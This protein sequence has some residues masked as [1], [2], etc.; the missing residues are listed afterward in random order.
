MLMGNLESASTGQL[1]AEIASCAPDQVALVHIGLGQH[2]EAM[3]WLEK[4]Y[5]EDAYGMVFL[6]GDPAVRSS[7]LGSALP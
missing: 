3:D 5:T 1:W 2:D 6:E 4:A 7:A